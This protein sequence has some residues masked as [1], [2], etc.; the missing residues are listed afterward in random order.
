[1]AMDKSLLARAWVLEY[2]TDQSLWQ[3]NNGPVFGSRVE[4]D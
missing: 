3:Q 2:F 1:M 4:S